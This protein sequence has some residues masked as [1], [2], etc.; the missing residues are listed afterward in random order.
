MVTAN[1]L[2][3]ASGKGLYFEAGFAKAL[4]KE[5]FW[6]CRF[7]DFNGL[8]VDTNHYGHIKWSEPRLARPV[9]EP[10][11][12]RDRARAIHPRL[13]TDSRAQ[14]EDS[15]GM[16]Q[17]YTWSRHARPVDEKPELSRSPVR[18]RFRIR[19]G[20]RSRNLSRFA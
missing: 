20:K 8:H 17:L 1:V 18:G 14:F 4:G 2:P 5:V 13:R 15:F 10:H 12:R 16:R 11:R 19:N 7:D 9:D 6:T 3:A